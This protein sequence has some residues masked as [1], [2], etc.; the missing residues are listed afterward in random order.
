[1]TGTVPVDKDLL[2]GT[3]PV[4][5]ELLTGRVPVNNLF[6]LSLLVQEVPVCS[7][8]VLVGHLLLTINSSV[9]FPVYYLGNCRKVARMVVNLCCVTQDMVS[10]PVMDTQDSITE[11]VMEQTMRETVFG[12][13]QEYKAGTRM[14]RRGESWDF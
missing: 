5:K 10:P 8:L 6:H 1:M 4:N 12:G 3:V 9:N 13:R 14:F 11:C 2:T 7:Q